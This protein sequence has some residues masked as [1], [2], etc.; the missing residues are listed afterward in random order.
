M[1]KTYKYQTDNFA[2]KCSTCIIV[3]IL[4]EIN[5]SLF[6]RITLELQNMLS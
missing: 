4:E 2:K 1:L 5:N 6:T 3:R